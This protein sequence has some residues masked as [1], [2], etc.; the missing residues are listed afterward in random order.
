MC[1]GCSLQQVNAAA[2]RVI[3]KITMQCEALLRA[4]AQ[5]NCLVPIYSCRQRDALVPMRLLPPPPPIKLSSTA[6]SAAATTRPSSSAVLL[7][8]SA[9][10]KTA[11]F[12]APPECGRDTGPRLAKSVLG[13]IC[14]RALSTSSYWREAGPPPPLSSSTA[15]PPPISAAA[16]SSPPSSSNTRPPTAPSAN[17]GRAQIVS[18]HFHYGLPQFTVPLPARNSMMEMTDA[19][20]TSLN[21]CHWSLHWPEVNVD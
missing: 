6:A 5:R 4:L 10:G 2:T 7:P 3:H 8:P 15:K 19:N 13:T 17:T 1:A 14:S 20:D 12:T 11:H 16:S 18:V 21:H 9:A